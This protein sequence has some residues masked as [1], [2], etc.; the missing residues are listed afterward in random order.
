[1]FCRYDLKKRWFKGFTALSSQ[2]RN[3]S[4]VTT[5]LGGNNKC[6]MGTVSWHSRALG[7]ASMYWLRRMQHRTEVENET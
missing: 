2:S 6:G 3:Q 5:L 1:M 7:T 4:R